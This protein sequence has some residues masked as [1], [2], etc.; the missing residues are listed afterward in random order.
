MT[1]MS[2]DSVYACAA[3][4]AAVA[5]WWL[6]WPMANM[7]ACP[8]GVNGQVYT[9]LPLLHLHCSVGLQMGS[10]LLGRMCSPTTSPFSADLVSSHIFSLGELFISAASSVRHLAACEKL[11]HTVQRCDDKI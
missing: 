9:K 8:Y 3:R 2:C 4:L 10:V 1:L 6:S 5:D 11:K 7:L